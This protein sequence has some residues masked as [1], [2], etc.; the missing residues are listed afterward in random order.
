MDNADAHAEDPFGLI[1]EPTA[2]ESKR[3][4]GADVRTKDR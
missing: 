3:V 1:D 2:K 4:A